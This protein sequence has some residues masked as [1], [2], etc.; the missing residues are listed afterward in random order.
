MGQ[1]KS[2][3]RKRSFRDSTYQEDVD[4]D[5]PTALLSLAHLREE[6]RF[7][8]TK[9]IYIASQENAERAPPCSGGR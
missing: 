3:M 5:L 2:K 4:W 9:D 7:Y 6:D 8:I 1:T